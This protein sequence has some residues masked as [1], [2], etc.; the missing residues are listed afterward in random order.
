V[1]SH[2][3]RA[4]GIK[5]GDAFH[6]L[7]LDGILI[8]TPIAPVVPKLAR[9]IERMRQDAGLTTEK[10]LADLR[11]QREQYYTERYGDAEDS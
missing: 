8:L 11:E 1:G 10:L 3:R 4:Y 9:E 2:T 6:L 5:P 7:D